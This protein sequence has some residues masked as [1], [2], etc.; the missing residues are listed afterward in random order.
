M[1]KKILLPKRGAWPN[2][3]KYATDIIQIVFTETDSGSLNIACLQNNKPPILTYLPVRTIGIRCTQYFLTYIGYVAVE[4]LEIRKLYTPTFYHESR[5]N[6]TRFQ[7][8]IDPVQPMSSFKIQCY[9]VY[10][11]SYR[12]LITNFNLICSLK[13]WEFHPQ[14]SS[15]LRFLN[16]DKL[17]YINR[18]GVT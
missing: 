4:N 7:G 14:A 11:Y 10:L 3:P 5:S 8:L 18:D 16:L 15:G 1:V 9:T 12:H 2:P 17:S 6:W 13:T